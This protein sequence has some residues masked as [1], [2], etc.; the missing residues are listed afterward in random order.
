M[1]Q[2]EKTSLEN[3]LPE[4]VKLHENGIYYKEVNI[5]GLNEP[6]KLFNTLKPQR[7]DGETRTEYR[8]RKKLEGSN[9]KKILFHNS[10]KL[11]TYIKN[12]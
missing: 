9:N 5:P 10:S 3:E 6:L 7:L 11:G 1:M 4:D 12:K 2:N 8:I